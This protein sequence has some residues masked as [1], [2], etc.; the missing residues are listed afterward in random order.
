MKKLVL[1][2]AGGL[3]TTRL[4]VVLAGP[5]LTGPS[6]VDYRDT[7][8]AGRIGWKEIV[9]GGAA[10][11]SDELRSYPESEL[12]SP[13]DDASIETTL[14]PTDGPA[15]PPALSSTR[16]LQAP[17]WTQDEGFAIF[18]TV[19]MALVSTGWGIALTRA[20]VQRSFARV[21]PGLGVLS[22]AFGVWYALGALDL[23]PYIF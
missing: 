14:T 15:A 19:S 16:S 2:L 18:T 9:V 22:L 21:A 4:E 12:E 20:P 23:A 17:G 13:L 7:N 5:R 8:F 1:V 11:T 3:P 10:S 6:R